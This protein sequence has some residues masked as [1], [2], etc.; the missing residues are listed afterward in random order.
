MFSKFILNWRSGI[1]RDGVF[2]TIKGKKVKETE[3]AVKKWLQK[4]RV[5][6]LKTHFRMIRN[7]LVSF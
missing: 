6:K 3:T 5:I 2:F 4:I 7:D 1:E